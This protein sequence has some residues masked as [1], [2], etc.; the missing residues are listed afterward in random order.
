LFDAVEIEALTAQTEKLRPGQARKTRKA[1]R[2]ISAEGLKNIIDAQNGRW[3]KV[4]AARKAKAKAAS[5][6]KAAAK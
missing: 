5:G 2:K 1:K 3:A 4:R 6:K